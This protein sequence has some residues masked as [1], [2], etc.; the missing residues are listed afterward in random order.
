[1]Y[2][3]IKSDR[4]KFL[5]IIKNRRRHEEILVLVRET[6]PTNEILTD[7]SVREKEF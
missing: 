5:I 6:F 7:K 4:E 2:D 3:R 1:M